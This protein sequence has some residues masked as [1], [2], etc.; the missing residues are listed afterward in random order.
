MTSSARGVALLLAVLLVF[1]S[2]GAQAQTANVTVSNPD[3]FKKSLEAAHEALLQFGDWDNPVELR[4]I[5]DIA[6]RLARETQ[7]EK[8]PYSYHLI[9]M[10]E[11]NAFALPG[12]QIFITRGMVELG[13]T[14]DMMACLVGH[15]M[16]HVAFEHSI[17]MERRATL[18][19]ILSQAAL[20]GVMIGAERGSRGSPPPYDPYG[21]G[22][23]QK[24][25]D[26]IQGTAAA[27]VILSEL[28]LR[29]YSRENEDQ[30]DEEGQRW[31]AAAGFNPD[32][33]RQ[34]FALMIARLPQDKKYGYWQ[35][36]PF[37]DTRIEA[38]TVRGQQL[39]IGTPKPVDELRQKTQ[40]VLLGQVAAVGAGKRP[41]RANRRREPEPPPALG[42]HATPPRED[43]G[44]VGLL[45]RE[46]LLAWPKGPRAETLRLESLH[47]K[48]DRELKKSE[49]L[50][51][52]GTV[53][54]SY[55]EQEQE[56]KQLTPESPLL[57]TLTDDQATLEADRKS[58]YP[59]A[60]KIFADGVYETPFLEVFESNWPEAPEIPPVALA[61]GDAY[62]RLNR[63]ADAVTQ[64]L[65]SW[66]AKSDSEAG[67]KALTGLRNLAGGLDQLAALQQL[68]TQ[69]DD[70]ELQRLAEQRLAG[71]ETTYTELSNGAE[72]LR[73]YPAGPHAPKVTERLNNLAS[74]LYG[75]IVLYQAIGDDMKAL[76]RINK[77]LT[78]APQSPA[79]D[80]L[81]ERAVVV[82]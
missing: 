56:V 1:S 61:L 72:Y 51:D 8:M 62:S 46:A 29:S 45:K 80:K 77:I 63:Q 33:T 5:A 16:A 68:A 9:D 12:G 40:E 4:R 70:A 34:L 53:L 42:E 35:T 59:K 71:L 36:H 58:Y 28:L 17:K 64:Y 24:S 10:P 78:Y 73:R 79:A 22:Q 18:L 82:S 38:A 26:M 2:T 74:S 66:E 55:R 20:L 52:Y 32:G 27:G 31:A 76:E 39:K 65:R 13:L 23:Q 44:V 60:Q 6:Y 37:F 81:R 30:A 48:R 25:S 57:K 49:L 41:D 67:K 11:P 14:D 50:R 15:E 69:K 54:R 7:Y 75:E 21:I 19:N 43:G 3:L 47:A